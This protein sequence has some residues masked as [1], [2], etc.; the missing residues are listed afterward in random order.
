MP[1]IVASVPV[2]TGMTPGWWR[3]WFTLTDPWSLAAPRLRADQPADAPGRSGPGGDGGG[4]GLRGALG[5]L[6]QR[7]DPV[8]LRGGDAAARGVHRRYCSHSHLNLMEDLIP[9]LKTERSRSVF[10]TYIIHGHVNSITF[11]AFY[12]SH[13]MKIMEEEGIVARGCV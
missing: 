13:G 11:V 8:H 6:L 4:A 1:N 12:R 5:L 3:R 2:R 7:L 9:S 10:F